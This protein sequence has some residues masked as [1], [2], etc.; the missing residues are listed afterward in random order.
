MY[1]LFMGGGKFIVPE[2]LMGTLTSSEYKFAHT[3]SFTK[4]S[5]ILCALTTLEHLT[6]LHAWRKTH[7][8][9]KYNLQVCAH[10]ALH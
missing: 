3:S 10:V 6:S 8:A 9:G 4:I 5:Y 2:N 7:R 1:S